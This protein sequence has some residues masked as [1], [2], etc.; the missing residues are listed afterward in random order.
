MEQIPRPSYSY[1]DDLTRRIAAFQIDKCVSPNAILITKQDWLKVVEEYE[2][3]PSSINVL[4][5]SFHGL[6]IIF[7]FC[8]RPTPI[9]R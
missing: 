2:E 5:P 4:D 3:C 9:I 7:V 8:G 1:A 6:P